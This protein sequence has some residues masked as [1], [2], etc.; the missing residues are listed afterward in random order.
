M[1]EE[2][3]V[4][5]VEELTEETTS[6]VEVNES[7]V[8][9][10]PMLTAK[11]AGLLPVERRE[12]VLALA[13]QI[14]V[15]STDKV[16]AYASNVSVKSTNANMDFL[17]EMAGE[18]EDEELVKRIAELSAKS[19]DEISQLQI[20]QKEKNFIQKMISLFIGNKEKEDMSLK[21]KNSA[22]ILEELGL[23][24][25]KQASMCKNLNT[26]AKE[27]SLMDKETI[28]SLTDYIIAGLI[29]MEHFKEE[30]E[31]LKE[32]GDSVALSTDELFRFQDIKNGLN[33]MSLVLKKRDEERESTYLSSNFINSTIGELNAMEFLYTTAKDTILNIFSQNARNAIFAEKVRS[34]VDGYKGLNELNK[35]L[36]IENANTH[37]ANFVDI[38][39]LLT[40]GDVDA[41]V[42]NQCID[43]LVKAF[44]E[45]KEMFEKCVREAESEQHGRAKAIEKSSKFNATL[46]GEGEADDEE[47][48]YDRLKTSTSTKKTGSGNKLEW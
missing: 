14:D 23:A 4:N 40:K 20:V 12:A 26:R 29:A 9:S 46:L 34:M 3:N 41:E 13:E 17:K 44:N 2:K 25:D 33:I 22:E 43:V 31:Q 28:D 1:V 19:K 32:N 27:L 18:K 36:M 10:L 37:A 7:D 47:T 30:A 21:A 6:I 16:M 5:T 45:G 48:V 15:T 42:V 24:L 38:V 39:G 11:S 35:N 8:P